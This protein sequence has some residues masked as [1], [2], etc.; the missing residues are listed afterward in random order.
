MRG[1]EGGI[2]Q[3]GRY[4]TVGGYDTGGGYRI[5]RGVYYRSGIC[6]SKAVCYSRG[7][8]YK[9]GG[10][11][12]VGGYRISRV[13]NTTTPSLAQPQAQV[14]AAQITHTNTRQEQHRKRP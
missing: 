5:R 13:S 6:Y 10:Y 14:G 12:T 9:M 7:I 1:I 4:A 8:W 3:F 11:G 2:I